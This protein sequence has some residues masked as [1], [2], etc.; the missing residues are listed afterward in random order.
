MLGANVSRRTGVLAAIG[1]MIGL[2]DA[3]E[4]DAARGSGR[5]HEK[6]A[7]RNANS[8]CT[9]N[10]ECCSN[11]CKPKFGGTGF[12][13]AK[14]HGKKK[15][16]GG[17]KGGG[18]AL[19]PTGAPCGPGD[20]CANSS[21][22]CTTYI[23]DQLPGTFC[24]LPAGKDCDEDSWCELGFCDDGVCAATCTVCS[25]GCPYTTIAGAYD[26][27]PANTPIAIAPGSYTE[28]ILADGKDGHFKLCGVSGFLSWTSSSSYV[29][30]VQPGTTV[31]TEG[32]YFTGSGDAVPTSALVRVGSEGG[33]THGVY[34][35]RYCTF[36]NH[37]QDSYS[38][39]FLEG[40]SDATFE[41]CAFFQNVSGDQ[42]GAIYSEGD[43][44]APALRNKLSITDCTLETNRAGD[45]V[46]SAPT[47]PGGAIWMRQTDATITRSTISGNYGAGGGAIAVNH[48]TSLVI[49][50]TTIT[51][52]FANYGPD[53]GGGIMIQ[54][55]YSGL[56]NAEIS[57]TLA[58][59]T[60]ITSNTAS[61]A[62]GIAVWYVDP[63]SIWTIVG[64]E[65]RVSNNIGAEQCAITEDYGVNW[66][67]VTNCAFPI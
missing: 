28:D 38:S 1:A 53:A 42:G 64:A 25:S 34:I 23:G 6:L 51:G 18:P 12:R 63:N 26:D 10:E 57:I 46:A 16:K 44:D 24:L 61:H 33:P 54:P 2:G 67:T 7:C 17:K 65:G 50:D 35:A 55:G 56:Q 58:G 37:N 45:G 31:T 27:L 20:T 14:A 9:S 49:T 32:I 41:N 66:T 30:S 36:Y 43:N 19:I 21:A 60:S 52:N 48:A 4:T 3:D 13:C 29:I 59:T 40:M 22:S 62:A 5:R 47:D 39:I 11:V 8:E 15:D